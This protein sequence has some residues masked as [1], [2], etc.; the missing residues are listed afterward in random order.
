MNKILFN[1]ARKYCPQWVPYIK[2]Q[3]A[4]QIILQALEN[5]NNDPGSIDELIGEIIDCLKDVTLADL[6][7]TSKNINNFPIKEI[8]DELIDYKKR[9]NNEK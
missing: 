8:K 9:M 6:L 3:N 4:E 7:V 2:F 5:L 1:L